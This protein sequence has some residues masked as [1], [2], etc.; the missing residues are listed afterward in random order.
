[1]SR[2][3]RTQRL[4]RSLRPGT[5]SSRADV[6][7][8][9]V[10]RTVDHKDLEPKYKVGSGVQSD[11]VEPLAK[12]NSKRVRFD[13]REF[14]DGPNSQGGAAETNVSADTSRRSGEVQRQESRSGRSSSDATTVPRRVEMQHLGDPLGA[15][16]GRHAGSNS[17]LSPEQTE[18]AAACICG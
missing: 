8:L 1:M 5:R 12:E 3:R 17:L 6:Y 2:G 11:S 7:R 13:L 15:D 4:S 14:G 9:L 10:S 18:A 16:P